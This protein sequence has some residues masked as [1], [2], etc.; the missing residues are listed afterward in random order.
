MSELQRFPD[1]IRPR[2]G[3]NYN[4]SG[5]N[6]RQTTISGGLNRIQQMYCTQSVIFNIEFN[7]VNYRQ[8]EIFN[9]FFYNV[10]A[11]GSLKF[12]MK[13]KPVRDIEE[14][15]CQ[16]VPGSVNVTGNGGSVPFTVT[17]QVEAEEIKAPYQGQLYFFYELGYDD[18]T[19]LS[20]FNRAA[21]F[22]NV[23]LQ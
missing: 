18:A 10:I 2:V 11:Q 19:V 13:L 6:L 20:I 14:H 5:R 23:D 4:H 3:Y 17:M 12:I 9:D 8:M 21:T 7:L 1:F 16:I 22:A 15:V